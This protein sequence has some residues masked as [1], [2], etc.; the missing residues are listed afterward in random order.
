MHTAPI[1]LKFDNWE[2]VSLKII[3]GKSNDSNKITIISINNMKMNKYG[4]NNIAKE[5]PKISDRG[6][7]NKCICVICF[8]R[9]FLLNSSLALSFASVMQ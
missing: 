1:N 5:I 3:L 9:F 4:K 8:N 7:V 6:K 2:L